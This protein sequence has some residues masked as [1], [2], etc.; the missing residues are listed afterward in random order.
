VDWFVGGDFRDD[1]FRTPLDW[2]G[3]L[4]GQA[5]FSLALQFFGRCAVNP[6]KVL[7]TTCHACSQA[8]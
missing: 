6:E 8:L 3:C 7:Q 4:L 1:F 2:L 5:D